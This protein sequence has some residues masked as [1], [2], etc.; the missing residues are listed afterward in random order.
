MR[1]RHLPHWLAL[2][3]AALACGAVPVA[4]PPPGANP[5]LPD[6][7]T[8]DPAPLVVAETAYLYGH[9]HVAPTT[10]T[11]SAGHGSCHGT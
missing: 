2:S 11:A 10:A 3:C 4:E 5:V 9:D 1:L 6:R 7:S 8:A